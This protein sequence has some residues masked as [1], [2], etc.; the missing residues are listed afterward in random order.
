M[1]KRQACS[2]P[3][4]LSR[5]TLLAMLESKIDTTKAIV[6]GTDRIIDITNMDYHEYKPKINSGEWAYYEEYQPRRLLISNPDWS[7][8]SF[9]PP[10]RFACVQLN[11]PKGTRILNFTLPELSP[12]LSK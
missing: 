4:T 1:I 5:S 12:R 10:T 2:N 3:Y 7:I 8:I 11:S 6:V 9:D